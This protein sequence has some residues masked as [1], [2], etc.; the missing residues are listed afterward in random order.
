M[1]PKSGARRCAGRAGWRVRTR[2]TRAAGCAALLAAV[3]GLAGAAAA[4]PEAGAASDAKVEELEKKVDVAIDEI[5]KLKKAAAVPLSGELESFSGLGP[6]ASKVYH[7][8]RGLSIGGYGEV[9]Y[10]GQLDRAG[11]QSRF[12]ALRAVLYVGY[13]FNDWIVFNSELEYEHAGE[14]VGVEFMTLDFLLCECF[15]LRAGLLLVPMGFI[16]EMHEPLFF[17]GAARPEVERRILPSTWR[18]NGAGFYGSFLEDRVQYRAY[19][20]NG[21]DATGFDES[22]LRGGRQKGSEALSDNFAFVLR[23]DTEPVGGLL[24][25]ASVYTGKSGQNQTLRNSAMVEFGVPDAWTTIWEVHGQ[26]QKAGAHVRALYTQAHVGDS[27][28]LSAAL[29]GAS[30]S[31]VQVA[32]RM[33]GDYIE[34]AYDVLPLV[35]P[36]TEMSLEPFYRYE[37]LD[38]Q[39]R[40]VG[41]AGLA[42]RDRTIH[43][44][45]VSF[46]PHPQVVVK[47]DYR[48]FDSRGGDLPD[49]VQAGIGF[50]F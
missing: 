28:A 6:A 38:T 45:G 27:G 25:G 42:T 4:E 8:D 13:K 24:L 3:V 7:R 26:F 14:E 19:V 2:S 47:L 1:A 16:N 40:V 50:V 11:G 12:D 5:D 10:T 48:N 20:V 44:V 29:T 37:R 22:G 23:V 39:D 17:Y 31:S 41:A 9:R 34:F 36:G 35:L 30:G 46:K 33:R 43:T 21:F 49:E 15:N 18:E 32:Q